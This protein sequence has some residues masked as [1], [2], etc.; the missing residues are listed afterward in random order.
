MW[1]EGESERGCRR[2]EKKRALLFFSLFSSSAIERQTYTCVQ[3]GMWGV[4]T[5]TKQNNARAFRLK[6]DGGGGRKR[7]WS[8]FSRTPVA[9]LFSR[10]KPRP[11]RPPRFLRLC[12]SLLRLQRATKVRPRS[13][14]SVCA[15][16]G[17]SESA[18]P[19]QHP[20]AVPRRRH[21][22]VSRCC[23]PRA[24]G[25]SM[26]SDGVA[27]LRACMRG[28]NSRAA[29][30]DAGARCS[31]VQCAFVTSPAHPSPRTRT[32]HLPVLCGA[33]H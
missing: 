5:R 4:Q 3:T 29:R 15:P 17:G 12:D 14:E 9:F 31:L 10:L 21:P 11:N 7:A 6:S 23:T 18:A 8:V 33:Q 32:L 13:R 1:C 22:G 24:N 20:H 2:G 16:R 26:P 27:P 19:S 30:G 25:A 28:P